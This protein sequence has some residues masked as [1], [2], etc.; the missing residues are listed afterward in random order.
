M[1]GARR[2]ED[3]G[4]EREEGGGWGRGGWTEGGKG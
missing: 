2:E 1:M 3:R 4:E